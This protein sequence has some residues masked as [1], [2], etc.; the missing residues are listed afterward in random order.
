MVKEGVTSLTC[1]HIHKMTQP[2]LPESERGVN[3][4][5]ESKRDGN[6]SSF[7]KMLTC[8]ERYQLEHRESMKP[9][10]PKL[11]DNPIRLTLKDLPGEV[12]VFAWASVTSENP[13][14][15]NTRNEAYKDDVNHCLHKTDEN[16]EVQ[17]T[18]NC[19][20][21]YKADGKTY[22]RHIHYVFEDKKEQTWSDKKTVRF[23]SQISRED[24]EEILDTK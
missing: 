3:V 13:L 16:G 24:L 11:G 20:Q 22:T 17:F 1:K 9:E 10:E 6:Y 5:D 15:I 8:D 21:P 19:P 18:L 7:P 4:S 23:T 12:W 14:H 2:E